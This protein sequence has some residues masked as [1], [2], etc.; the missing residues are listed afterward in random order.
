[1]Y[2]DNIIDSMLKGLNKQFGVMFCNILDLILTISTLYFLLPVWGMS[3]YLFATFISEIFNFLVSYIQLHKAIGFHLSFLK[4]IFIPSIC[5]F[6]SYLLLQFICFYF[7]NI[8]FPLKLL[9]FT[10]C[11]VFCFLVRLFV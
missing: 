1:M 3:G 8:S 5:A 6:F 10:A 7:T 4:V 11:F 2:L 9:L